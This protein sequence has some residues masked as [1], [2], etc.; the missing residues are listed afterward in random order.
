MWGQWMKRVWA[1]LPSPADV[2]A[3]RWM[4]TVLD[5]DV[6]AAAVS[7]AV[8]VAVAAPATARPAQLCTASSMSDQESVLSST[9]T[10][11]ATASSVGVDSAGQNQLWG[12]WS[13]IPGC[14]W[15][16]SARCGL[17]SHSSHQAEAAPV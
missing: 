7:V 8:A 4:D 16:G 6:V 13:S 15:S 1:S 11:S 2:S 3:P 17:A 5:G 9:H 12:R 14:R 10:S